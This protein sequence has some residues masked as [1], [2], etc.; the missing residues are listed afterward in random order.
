MRA[1]LCT[2]CYAARAV[3]RMLWG[4]CCA[5]IWQN[6][7]PEDDVVEGE[8]EEGG[9]TAGVA[10]NGAQR[11]H[12]V[13]DVS[14]QQPLSAQ[15][16]LRRHYYGGGGV[17]Q[18]GLRPVVCIIHTLLSSSAVVSGPPE[19]RLP[20]SPSFL[21][22]SFLSAASSLPSSEPSSALSLLVKPC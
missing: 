16:L 13:M 17:W 15:Q 4:P 8:D 11:Q 7:T 10:T 19:L 6:W 12:E 14:A 1:M 21:Y 9:A 5:Q 20:T 22:G 2:P 3:Q 18:H